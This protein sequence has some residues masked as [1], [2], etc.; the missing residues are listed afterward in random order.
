VQQLLP[1]KNSIMYY[2]RVC[3]L[4]CPA[5]KAHASYYIVICGLSGSIIFFHIISYTARFSEKKKK[6]T[7]HKMCVLILSSNFVRNISQSKENPPR[8]HKRTYLF[9]QSTRYS[10]QIV[11]KPEFSPHIFEKFSNIKFHVNPSKGS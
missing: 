9:M 1:R 5:C 11:F 2:D 10:W 6:G 7:E 3:S 4:T 8:Y